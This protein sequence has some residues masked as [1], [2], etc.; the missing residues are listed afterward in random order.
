MLAR[1]SGGAAGR[2]V[3]LP[4]WSSPTDPQPHSNLLFG[5]LGRDQLRIE[6]QASSA[7][8]TPAGSTLDDFAKS[9][10]GLAVDALGGLVGDFLFYFLGGGRHAL[11]CC[12]R[13]KV[14]DIQ[15][16]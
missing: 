15:L 4:N 9:L 5:R 11:S 8:Q 3:W 6:R 2:G 12:D 14:W 13:A 7:V 10:P 16:N 1:L